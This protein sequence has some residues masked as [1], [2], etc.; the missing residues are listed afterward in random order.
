MLTQIDNIET[1]QVLGD[2][3]WIAL[4]HRWS[5]KLWLRSIHNQSYVITLEDLRYQ[6]VLG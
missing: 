2:R 4:P 5:A 3:N 1:V 6:Q